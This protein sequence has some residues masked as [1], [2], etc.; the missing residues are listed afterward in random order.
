MRWW[1]G[2]MTE[3]GSKLLIQHAAL[4]RL[5]NLQAAALY[6]IRFINDQCNIVQYLV[7]VITIFSN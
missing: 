4:H 7:I 1:D 3:P 2:C 6:V 5:S